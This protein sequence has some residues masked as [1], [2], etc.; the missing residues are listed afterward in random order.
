MLEDVARQLAEGHLLS[1]APSRL[2]P[3]TGRLHALESRFHDVYQHFAT[4]S[5]GALIPSHAADWVLDNYFVVQRALRQIRE[6]L[7]DGFYRQLPKLSAPPYEGLPRV[8]ALAREINRYCEGLLDLEITRRFVRAYQ[9]TVPLT[10]GEIWALPTMLRL[11]TLEN[12]VEA[13]IRIV[14]LQPPEG[15]VDPLDVPLP[16][17]AVVVN[18][19]L[20]LRTIDSQDWDQFFESVS[21][22]EQ[23]LRRDP[24]DVYAQMDFDTRDRYR[25]VVEELAWASGSREGEIAEEAIRLAKEALS[26]KG[27]ARMNHVGYYLVDAGRAALEARVGYRPSWKAGL[28]R[29]LFARPVVVYLGSIALLTLLILSLL[30]RY[31][32]LAGGRPSH[33]IATGVLFL[34][35]A[36][37]VS[38]SLVNWFVTLVVPPR[39]LPKL[40]LR[41]GIPA[42]LRT[43]VA[44]PALLNDAEDV[45]PLSQQLEL[46][47]LGNADPHLSFA[48]L[49]DF[50][51]APHQHMPGDQALLELMEAGVREL[52]GKYGQNGRGPFY[53]FHRGRQ[54]N[55]SENCWMG[56]ERKRGKL[57]EFNRLILGREKVSTGAPAQEGGGTPSFSLQVGDLEV[58]QD[59]RYVITLDEDTSLQPG[60]AKRLVAT[61]AHPLNHA[62]FDP[63]TGAVVAGYTVLQPRLEIRPTS[64][65]RSLFAR[66]FAGDV[67][68]D[69]YTRAVSEVYQDWFGEGIYAGKGIFDVAA[70]ERSLAGRV[71]ENALLSHDLFEGIHGRTGLVTDVTLLEEYPPHYLT[72]ARRLHRWVC[73]DWQLLPWLLPKVPRPEGGSAPN[74]LSA[75][76]RWKILDNLRRSILSPALLLC[77]VAGWLWLPGSGLVWTLAGVLTQAVPIAAAILTGL[78]RRLR[79]GAGWRGRVRS[80]GLDVARWLLG[81]T[82]LP[83]ETLI[84]T[85]A[86]LSTLV[87][88]TITHKHLLQWTTSAHTVRLFAKETRLGLLWGR[89]TGAAVLALGLALL[90]GWFKPPALPVSLPLL[91][92]WVSSPQVAHWISR[93]PFRQTA[94][95]SPAQR[96]TLRCLARRTWHFFE[97]FMGPDDHWLVPDHFQEDPRGLLAHRTSPTNLGLTLISALAAFDLGY[98]GPFDLILRLRAMFDGMRKLERFRGHLL[99]WYDTR[100]LNPLP[101]RYVSTVDSGNLAACL[102]ALKQGCLD[103]P[104]L[105]ILR[106]ER[107]EGLLDA[108]ALLRGILNSLQE[109]DLDG[110]HEALRACLE[111]IRRQVL[112]ARGKPDDWAWLWT[113]LYQEDW[114]ELNQRLL[115]FLEANAAKFEVP[116][117]GEL[118]A[119]ADMIHLHLFTAHRDVDTFLP[120]SWHVRNQPDL[121]SQPEVDSRLTEAGSTLLDA[122]PTVIRLDKI[123]EVTREAQARLSEFERRLSDGIGP[124]SQVEDARAWCTALLEGTGSARMAAEALVIGFR[125]LAE[126]IEALFQAMDFRFLYDQ[127]RRVFHIGFNVEAGRLDANYYDLLASEARVASLLAIA[128]GDVPPNHWLQLS[129]PLTLVD[130]TRVLLSWSGTMF[131]Y[132]MPLLFTQTYE[133]TLLDQSCRAAVDRQIAHGHHKGVPWGVSESGYY[134]FDANLNYQYRAFG[135]QGLGLKRGLGD[136]LVVSP[137]AS[138][139]ALGLKPRAVLDNVERMRALGMIG[140]YGFYEAVDYTRSRLDPGQSHAVVRSYMAHHQGMILLA[141]ANCLQGEAVVRRVHADPRVKCMEFL[142]Q[143]QVSHQA[144]VE[145]PPPEEAFAARPPRPV[146]ETVSWQVQ[147]QAPLPEVNLLSNG[148][149]SVLITS[150]GS[151]F[152]RW[153][154]VDLTRWRA[155]ATL[156]EWGTWVYIQDRESGALWSA[157]YQPTATPAESQEVR[158]YAHKATFFRRDQGVSLHMEITVAPEDDVE[159]RHLT[160]TNHGDRPRQLRVTSFS[161]VVLSAHAVDRRHPAFNRLFVESEYLPEWNALL[162]RRRPRSVEEDPLFLL[163]LLAVER[164]REVTGGHESDRGRFLGRG[165]TTRAPMALGGDG[166]GPPPVTGASLDPIMCLEQEVALGPHATARLAYLTVAAASRQEAIDQALRHRGWQAIERAFERA[167]SQ[168]E[169]ELGQLGIGGREVEQF[170][171]LHA[172]LLYPH[173]ALRAEPA[174][175]AANVKGQSGLWAYGISGDYPI[176]LA[177][178]GSQEESGLVQ[179]LLRAHAF[180]R[181]RQVKIDLVVLNMQEAGYSQELHGQLRSLISKAHG[182]AWLNQ[183]GGIF[184]LRAGHMAEAGRVLLRTAARAVL[185][186]EEGSL[187]EQLSQIHVVRAISLPRFTP[188]LPDREDVE[189]TPPLERPG[190]LLFDNG[191]GGFSPDGREYVIYLDRD[192]WTPAP[193]INVIASPQFGFMVSETGAGC[194]WAVNSGENRLT[195][196]HNDPVTGA[197]GEA[198]YLRDEETGR[199]WSP[200]PLPAR[201]DAPYLIRHG[202]GHSTFEHASHGLRQLVR[203][204]A[205]QDAPLKVIRLRLENVWNRPRR[206]TATYYAEWVL[207]ATRDEMQPYIVPEYDADTHALIA[208]NPYNAEFGE[209][210]AF[211]AGGQEPHSLTADRAEFL[212]RMG[213]LRAPEALERMGLASSVE[214]GF[215]PCGALQLHIDLAAGE[216]KEVFFLLGEGAD[217][218]EALALIRQHQKP[219]RVE[220]AWQRLRQFWEDLLGAVTVKTPDPAMN[221]LLNGWL[222]YQALSCRVWGRSALYQSSGAFGF[223]DQLQDVMALA[224]VAPDV[225]RDHILRAARHQFEAGDVLHW[226]HPPSG[227]GVRTR[228]SDDLLWLPYV[229]AYYVGITGDA[230][231]LQEEVPF[232][233]GKAL[234]PEE[235]ERY[236]HY[237]T[238]PERSSLYDHCCRAIEKG[239]TAGPHGLPLIGA[240][241]WNDGLDRVG[242][243]GEGESVWVGWFLC[244]TLTD[245]SPLCARMG[246]D[247]RAEAYLRRARELRQA[248]EAHAW[249]GDW[250]RR[251]YYDDGTPLG[252]AENQECQIDSIVQSWAVLA[253]CGG[254]LTES[255]GTTTR[256]AQAMEAV[257]ERLVRSDDQLILLLAPPFD[258]TPLDPGY[259]KGY[260]P[261]VRENGGQYTHAALWAVWAYAGLGQGDRAEALFRLLNPIYRSDTADKTARYRVEPY[262]VAADVYSMPPHTGRGGWTWY[263]G[264]AGWMYRLGLEAILGLR[265]VGKRL[266]LQPCIPRGWSAYELIYRDG[267]TTY[268]IHVENPDGVN[269]G[270]RRVSLDGEERREAEVPLLG[271]GGRH[272]VDVLMG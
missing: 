195:T 86:I 13:A 268:E 216:A 84:L 16:D 158:F 201:E 116:F 256:A 56:W 160:L 247:D 103:L 55:P 173:A 5:E 244:A 235:P 101:P 63:R 194:S 33:W 109:R 76:D 31:A 32:L 199:V 74:D 64:A 150:A 238:S 51:D 29:W 30:M 213:S 18:S 255:E 185:K 142:M 224:H 270:V 120:W 221:L 154:D 48:L 157:G 175:L 198:L 131:E 236:D 133:G 217:R 137:Y 1:A 75:L 52:N 17:E 102:L 246:D 8:L 125:E 170:Q 174:T 80:L 40:A 187:T 192:Q 203:F 215:D 19:I 148:R 58:L 145:R 179:E 166:S 89:V 205:P 78:V 4:T 27:S 105:P 112:A 223:R 190:G 212:G 81:L 42:E 117:L 231:I 180:W 46:H 204:F 253:A 251:A 259:I 261:G 127:R 79:Q 115:S 168:S 60:S 83:Y 82:F 269:T 22:V 250:Y 239:S 72:Y 66:I 34:V 24:S 49:T 228:C 181:R 245:F 196:W 146:T 67:G 3:L 258:R 189:A 99:N 169:V 57:A 135:V 20:G 94:P 139:L 96:Q 233:S 182:D 123:S 151:G 47:Y 111:G 176:L 141:L 14:G 61:L 220:T 107:W 210:V 191:L 184:L 222:L 265:R 130:G 234:E 226:W 54:W 208:R 206:V 163:H 87:R 44:V 26:G 129:R 138:L 183:R 93:P 271:D 122:L 136:D 15:E 156:D 113:K 193:W 147:P 242:I 155:D 68:L 119:S 23:V 39:I 114:Q 178:V 171:R 104:Q 132:L 229:T 91:L 254:E 62:E 266:Q 90:V 88:L 264:S 121:L 128:K 106:W 164:G 25:K 2:V 143:E 227:R 230:A 59:V 200:T 197:S 248:M 73:G 69:L 172:V 38:V 211:L 21:L 71:P 98:L 95:L 124:E 162:F 43:M 263:T 28:R 35:P 260:P 11:G 92:M 100:T 161:E 108:L 110:P 50:A 262:V 237:E 257:F 209:R 97:R 153:R 188:T 37:S 53:L 252:S 202:A 218:K 152:S 140:R 10:M 159:I 149:Y 243:E 177:E 12:L 186:G 85:D 165:G 7:P 207:G 232:L 6:D 70:F 134:A 144:P 241:D 214:A 272:R 45:A 167:Q 126:Q 225:L 77:L 249:D 267:G 219:E 240:G 9:L 41:Q 65:N 36:M 118:R